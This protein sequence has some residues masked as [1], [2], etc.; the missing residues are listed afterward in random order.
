MK[1]LTR[2]GADFRALSEPTRN[3]GEIAQSCGFTSANIDRQLA[4]PTQQGLV[5]REL[6]GTCAR[7]R[8]ADDSVH[9]PCDLVCGSIG[10]QKERTAAQHLPEGKTSRRAG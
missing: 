1:P 7:D 6:R 2:R 10:Q 3:D 8:I 4:A 9:A 5:M